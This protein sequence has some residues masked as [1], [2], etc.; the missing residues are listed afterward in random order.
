MQFLT[1]EAMSSS[2][3]LL[4][5]PARWLIFRNRLSLGFG[6]TTIPK[7]FLSTRSTSTLRRSLLLK[8]VDNRA[9]LHFNPYKQ[10]NQY[11]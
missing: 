9:V 2:R 4:Y 10:Y 1:V 3:A 7:G 6:S 5:Q 11:K 8:Q